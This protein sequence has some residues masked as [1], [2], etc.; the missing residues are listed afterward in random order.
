MKALIALTSEQLGGKETAG[1]WLIELAKQDGFTVSQHRF[2]DVLN[3]ILA[4]LDIDKTRS[5]LQQLAAALDDAF[6]KGTITK[7]VKARFENDNAVILIIDGVRWP[8]D[9]I[10]VRNITN[11]I[12]IYITA[13]QH[14][15]W[16]RTRQRCRS[17]EE[18]KSL[19]EFCQDELARTEVDIPQIGSRADIK[20][21]N[22]GTLEEFDAKIESLWQDIKRR[23]RL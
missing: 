8:S 3:D 6:G 12:L 2:S 22:N 9:E 21:E 5:N 17:G 23:F 4:L 10:M 14:L 19:A 15:R 1:K 20:I 16:Q 7:A 13:D 18:N 11:S